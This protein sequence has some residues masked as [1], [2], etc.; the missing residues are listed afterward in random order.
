MPTR[1]GRNDPCPCGSSKK[2]KKCHLGSESRITSSVQVDPAY[3]QRRM[4]AARI[5]R[6]RQQGLGRPIIAAEFKGE[7]FVAVKN[8]L[9]RTVTARR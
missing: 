7:R 8:R 9:D 3:R 6:E 5:Q 1:P 4:E 2:F